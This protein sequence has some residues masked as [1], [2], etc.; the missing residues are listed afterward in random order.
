NEFN[1]NISNGIMDFI[2]KFGLLGLMVLLYRYGK[3]C[4]AYLRKT[5]Y[6]CYSILILLILS[7]GEPILM[8]PICVIFIFL[9]TFKK[10]DFT[11]LSFDYRSKYLPLKRPN[12]I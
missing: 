2:T 9:P 12:T 10:Q 5:E 6:V 1:V 3:L 8:L 11:A 7:F 4:R